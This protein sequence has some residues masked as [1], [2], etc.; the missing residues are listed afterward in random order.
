MFVNVKVVRESMR[1]YER[2]WESKRGIDRMSEKKDLEG[3]S[4]KKRNIV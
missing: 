3:F 4:E 1:E 2:V